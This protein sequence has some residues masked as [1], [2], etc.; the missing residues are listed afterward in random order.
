M[1]FWFRE[2]ASSTQVDWDSTKSIPYLQRCDYT[3]STQ[4]LAFD[5]KCKL[6]KKEIRDRLLLSVAQCSQ[7]PFVVLFGREK[8]AILHREST[9][10]LQ[11]SN[12]TGL[13]GAMGPKP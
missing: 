12:I 3:H 13:E 1:Y 10:L 6:H 5:E 9:Q 8:K 11:T 4:T 7:W 2:K